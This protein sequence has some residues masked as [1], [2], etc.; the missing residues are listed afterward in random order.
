M[1]FDVEKRSSNV[2]LT[3]Y[4]KVVSMLYSIESPTLDFGSMSDK[5]YFDV[6]PQR[7][8]NVD[9]K[10]KSYLDMNQSGEIW[11]D[12]WVVALKMCFEKTIS[13][14]KITWSFEN[15]DLQLFRCDIRSKCSYYVSIVLKYTIHS[16]EPWEYI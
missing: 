7:W 3:S 4:T 1:L 13:F 6:D 9:P 10:F 14:T 8:N 12:I 16:E 5:S 11:K 15:S 2:V